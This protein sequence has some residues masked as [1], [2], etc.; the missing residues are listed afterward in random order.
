[1]TLTSEAAGLALELGWGEIM[2]KAA[3]GRVVF[4]EVK[5]SFRA[6]QLEASKRPAGDLTRR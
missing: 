3:D 1:M 2:L 4:A 6:D 5:Q